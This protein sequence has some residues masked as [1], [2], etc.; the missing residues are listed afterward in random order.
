MTLPEPAVAQ[1]LRQAEGAPLKRALQGPLNHQ[2]S[3]E[4]FIRQQ[5]LIAAGKAP[6]DQ[7]M[8]QEPERPARPTLPD[9]ALVKAIREVIERAGGPSFEALTS[10]EQVTR[11]VCA[12]LW[13]RQ[14]AERAFARG[15]VREH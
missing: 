3:R 8:W 5:H 6:T 11:W 9:P 10:L 2:R 12:T 14:Y 13:A 1:V 4:H 15:S 7:T